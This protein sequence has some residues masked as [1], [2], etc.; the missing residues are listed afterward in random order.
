[1]VEVGNEMTSQNSCMT[2]GGGAMMEIDTGGLL[3]ETCVV[4]DLSM[5]QK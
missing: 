2:V 5:C 4:R 3:V 1:M